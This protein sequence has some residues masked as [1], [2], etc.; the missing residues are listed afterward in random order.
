MEPRAQKFFAGLLL[1]SLTAL[2]LLWLSR[3]DYSEKIST[4][5]IDLIP[6]DERSPELSLVRS[7]VNDRQSRTMLFVLRAAGAPAGSG[8]TNT[9]ADSLRGSGL[10]DD[11]VVLSDTKNRDELGRF[12]YEKRFELLL[13]RYLAAKK[14]AYEQAKPKDMVFSRWLAESATDDL[15]KFLGRPESVAFQELLPRDP[16]LLV[17]TLAEHAQGLGFGGGGST[18]QTGLVWALLKP[19]PFTEQGQAPVFSAVEKARAAATALEPKLELEWSGVNRFA[20][21]SRERISKELSWLN[22]LSLIAVLGVTCVFVRKIWKVIHLVPVVLFSILGA[23]VISTMAFHRL[24]ILVFVV[25]S[26]LSGVAID[27]GFYLYMQPALRPDE[28]YREKLGRLMKPLL[29]SCLTTVIGFSFLLFSELPLIRQLGV[30]VSA[31]LLSALLGAILYFA[32]LTRP[33]LETRSLPRPETSG[34]KKIIHGL[35]IIAAIAAV[36][37]ICHLT[38][39]DDVR[40]LEVPSPELRANDE[41]VRS[42]F[43]DTEA[44]SM[45]LTRE[46]TPAA[47]R[48]SLEKFLVWHDAKYPEAAGASLGWLIPTSQEWNAMAAFRNELERF[49]SDFRFSLE[50]HGYNPGSFEPFFKA[51]EDDVLAAKSGDYSGV[52]PE[53]LAHLSG[54][55]SLL[56]SSSKEG[57]WFITLANHDSNLTPPVELHTFFVSQL[58]SLNGLFTRYRHSAARLSAMGLALVGLSVFVLYGIKRGVRIFCIP[59]GSCVFA[60]GILGLMGQPLNLFHLLGAFLGVCLSHNY[61]IFSA[62]NAGRREP[63]PP[64][65][66][67]SALCTAASFSVLAFSKIPVVSALGTIVSITVLTALLMVE[68]EPITARSL[69]IE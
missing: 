26:L 44:R 64:S 66:R 20:A 24:H 62:E 14:K 7:L 52:I 17:P 4:N 2:G 1:F 34:S 25:G 40:Q 15:E 33:F 45:Y 57:T 36:W 16:F 29:A 10:F 55:L 49:P 48:D 21:D 51:W 46:A 8:V 5:V 50:H 13:P 67:L 27:Y 60:F 68:L 53:V 35:G 32:L 39:R 30:F 56:A 58:E 65:I 42:Y 19:S 63:P 47:A 6:T 12:I 61:A 41:K 43:G 11:V 22:T 37:G 59:A 23:W 18:P 28:T 9:F 54:P 38:W 31:G 69:D 3:I